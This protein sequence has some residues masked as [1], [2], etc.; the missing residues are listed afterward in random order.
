V[1]V[2]AVVV[3]VLEDF[4]ILVD[5][6]VVCIAVVVV[7]AVAGLEEQTLA[8]APGA[9]L[10]L[11][12]EVLAVQEPFH[13]QVLVVLAALVL[14]LSHIAAEMVVIG[15][16]VVLVTVFQVGVEQVVLAH[17]ETPILLGT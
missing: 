13:R 5:A 9:R 6:A 7:V 2:V 3:V 17:Q 16:Q 8:A 11:I 12:Q 15:V 14:G 4:I 10:A 1:A